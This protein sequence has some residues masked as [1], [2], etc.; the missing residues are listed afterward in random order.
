MSL[1]ILLRESY[2]LDV[3]KA[4]SSTDLTFPVFV[5]AGIACSSATGLCVLDISHM[6]YCAS[7]F[8]RAPYNYCACRRFN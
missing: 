4:P 1:R 3:I 5:C 2:E 8:L 7:S 6:R